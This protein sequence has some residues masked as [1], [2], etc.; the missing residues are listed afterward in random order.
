M[1]VENKKLEIH[2]VKLTD[3]IVS[4]VKSTIP[5]IM[6][7]AIFILVLSSLLFIPNLLLIFNQ[8]FVSI[9]AVTLNI[10]FYYSGFALYRY[11]KQLKRFKNETDGLVLEAA[12]VHQKKYWK[13]SSVILIIYLL[14]LLSGIA[15]FSSAIIAYYK[16]YSGMQ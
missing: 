11:A 1:N 4:L 5:W 16:M 14:I 7:H 12:F 10:L 6:F 15:L 9:P 13:I 2:Y 8:P 3:S